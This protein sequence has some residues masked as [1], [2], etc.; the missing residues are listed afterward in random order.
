MFIGDFGAR[1][2]YVCVYVC[3]GLMRFF[4]EGRSLEIVACK[5]A[6]HDMAVIN[7]VNIIMK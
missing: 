5:L 4:S 3:V 1:V 7:L 2:S 6:A